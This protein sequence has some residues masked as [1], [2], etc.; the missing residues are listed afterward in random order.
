MFVCSF[1]LNNYR[2]L[3]KTPKLELPWYFPPK[4]LIEIARTYS[5]SNQLLSKEKFSDVTNMYTKICASNIE[6]EEEIL[7]DSFFRTYQHEDINTYFIFDIFTF[8]ESIFTRGITE[9]IR[10]R[11]RL[12]GASF[13]TSEIS[14]FWNIYNFFGTI[15]DIRSLAVHGAKWYKKFEEFIKNSNSEMD[16]HDFTIKVKNFRDRILKYM[17]K[18]ILFII[19]Q[20]L[21]NPSFSKEFGSDVLYFFN[22]N[23]TF[24][25]TGDKETIIKILKERYER[26]KIKYKDK[27]EEIADKLKL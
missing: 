14:A 15:Y 10:L 8:F 27:W 25:Q 1:Y 2:F 20:R 9:Y 18:G 24:E 26:L 12:N 23:K 17:N 5:E 4:K 21:T 11:F 3:W 6:K 13:L 7:L 16:D 19:E 22:K